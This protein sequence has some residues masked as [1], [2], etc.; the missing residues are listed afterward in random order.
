[1]PK[2]YIAATL[3][4]VLKSVWAVLADPHWRVAMEE[5]HITLM[6]NDTWDLVPHPRGADVVTSKLNFKH[7][8]KANGTLERYK[9]HWVLCGFMQC[10]DVGYDVTFST[11]VKPATVHTILSL[12]VSQD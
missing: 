1:L 7:K 9:A 11:I 2:L 5:E 12:A 3:S 6:S 4:P 10:P 8:F